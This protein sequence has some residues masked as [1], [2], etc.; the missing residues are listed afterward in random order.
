MKLITVL[1]LIAMAAAASGNQP[2]DLR[3]DP[4][5]EDCGSPAQA[6]TESRAFDSTTV[7]IRQNPCVDFEANVLY[8]LLGDERALLVDSGASDD[9]A[10]TAELAR[11]VDGHRLRPDGTRLPLTVVHTH[12]HGDHHAGDAALSQL[13]NVI[14]MPLDSGDARRF[15]NL[16]GWPD[17]S[18][19]LDLGNRIVDIIPAPG[20]HE[21]HVVFYD[22]RTKLLLTGDFL[23]PG[24]LLVEDLRAYE[25]SARRVAD[26]VAG[27]PVSHVLG[28]HIEL[29]AAGD[30]YSHGA[31]L[32]ANERDLALT[33][34]DVR[35][36]PAALADFNGFYSHHPDYI[37]VNPMHNLV[38][39]GTGVL[40][41][42]VLAVWIV[43]RLWK[44]RRAPRAS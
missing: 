21:D 39:L 20:H 8:L 29:D 24:R 27:H 44:L 14:V 38:A 28:A 43:R 6:R 18:A 31:T 42:L 40:V 25:A 16:D 35:G 5:A 12:G 9:P 34:D 7:I 3:W 22:R 10:D 36:L 4:G 23:L 30:A 17:G 1:A 33:A 26:F 19:A 13:P 37:V 2:L 41:A 11:I 32:H 15:L